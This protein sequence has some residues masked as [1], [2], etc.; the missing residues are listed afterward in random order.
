MSHFFRNFFIFMVDSCQKRPFYG[1]STIKSP[2]LWEILDQNVTLFSRIFRKSLKISK[3]TSVTLFYRKCHTL[4]NPNPHSMHFYAT[5][6]LILCHGPMSCLSHCDSLFWAKMSY[7]FIPKSSFYAPL[8]PMSCH[9]GNVNRIFK[10]FFIF[11]PHPL[12]EPPLRHI[13]I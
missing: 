12:I 4:V 3:L 2:F 5:F 7:C 6:T 10:N 8:L 13:P 9:T 11:L 1:R